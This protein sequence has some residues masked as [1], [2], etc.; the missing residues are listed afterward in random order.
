[1]KKYCFTFPLVFL[2][3]LA[4]ILF[5]FWR[6]HV[7]QLA[8][9]REILGAQVHN[10]GNEIEKNVLRFTNE[11]NCLLFTE[12]LTGIINSDSYKS[13][14]VTKIELLYSNYRDLIKNIYIYDQNKNVV[15]L[16][17]DKKNSLIIDPYT[18]QKQ[19]AL[20]GKELVQKTQEGYQYSLPI[21]KNSIL[22]GNIVLS[23]DFA[24]YIYAV[25]EKYHLSQALWQWITDE[26]GNVISYNLKQKVD[27]SSVGKIQADLKSGLSGS[28]SHKLLINE[29]KVSFI[30]SYYLL[31]LMNQRLGIVFSLNNSG[32]TSFLLKAFLICAVFIA[33]LLA[34]LLYLLKKIER[35]YKNEE[36]VSLEYRNLK[37]ILDA[38]PLGVMVMDSK[39]Q[40]RLMNPAAREMLHIREGEDMHRKNILDRFIHSKE[41]YEDENSEA[42]FDS[43]QFVLYKNE[44]EEVV[45]YKKEIPHV[46]QDEEMILSAFID[47]TSIEKARKYEAASNTA[48][49]EFLAKMSHE[50][51]T[52]MNGIIGMTEALHQ[53]NLTKEQKEYVEI[54]RKSAD[55]LLNLIDDLLDFSKIEAGKMQLEEIPFKLR[56]E[57]KIALDLFRAI[58]EEKKL[59]LTVKINQN[60]PDNI[61]GDPFRLR[62]V[63]SNLISNAVKFTH[64]GEI[65]VGTELD[66]EYDGNLT[67]LFYVEDTGVG[68]P[69]HKIESIFNS[70]TQADEST[71][72]KYGG[73][74][75]GTTISKQLVTL[76]NGEIWVESPSTISTSPK[77]PGSKFSFT[78]EV[79][80]NEKLIKNIKTDHITRQNQIRT[81]IITQNVDIKRR[82]NKFLESE[83]MKYDFFSYQSEKIHE[84]L[85]MLKEAS[86]PYHILFIV[87]DTNLNG[88]LLAKKL[89]D[90]KY[91][92]SYIVFM[93]SSNHKPENFIQSKRYGVDYYLIEPFE[94]NDILG[95]IYEA[96]YN[97]IRIPAESVKKLKGDISVLVAEDNII[98]QKVA[99]TIFGQLGLSI[100]IAQNGDEVIQKIMEKCYDIVFMDL[101][102]PDRDGIQATVELRGQGYQMPIVAMTATASSKSKS[103]ALASGM[104]DYITKPVRVE[105]VKNILYKW[106]A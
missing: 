25:A 48:K 95:Y 38:L 61:I 45:V 104:N 26:N 49:S 35:R 44:G 80:S 47:I 67:L 29:K 98:N 7:R 83:Q 102:M 60:V 5:S 6:I 24:K 53:E 19:K 42:A 81:L 32:F 51:R 85:T 99:I 43:N 23:L 64:E 56:D 100:D 57:V 33:L 93:I 39:H 72:R 92:D 34:L 58:I 2:G 1:M 75:L 88:M 17:Y 22:V 91:I 20:T 82:L 106:F 4:V 16:F 36:K 68:I 8:Y 27:F 105:I 103:R 96:F 40:I 13:T 46:I 21:Y 97:I 84:L 86:T 101:M 65:V 11:V 89:R 94:Y 15:N 54:V 70:F 41:Y 50:I 9:Q 73:S 59:T 31:D 77:Y 76:M 79:F 55:L 78:I 37:S 71:S 14:A 90:D 52:P 10:C 69:H 12:D 63:L 28:Y 18:A 74:G 30:S 66:E 87:D 62:Q 3:I